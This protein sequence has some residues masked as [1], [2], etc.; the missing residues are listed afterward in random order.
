M[1]K[2][3]FSKKEQEVLPDKPIGFGYK[4]KW[5]AIKSN[6]K[7]KVA[8]LLELK[9]IKKSNW[10][11]GIE[12]GYKK[13]IFITPEINGWIL[14]LGIDISD[15]EI[16][17]TKGLLK[18]VSKKFGECQIFLTHRIVE[19]HFWGLARDGKIERLYSYA[20]ESNE[21]MIIEG[22]PTEAERKYNFVNTFLE[23]ANND[24]YW[25]RENIEF[26]DEDMV[27][28]IAKKWS[29]NPTRIE[30]YEGV[31]GIGLIGN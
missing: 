24:E 3:Y 20:G 19:Y 11:D 7:E 18:R 29:I 27:M 4:N 13:G 28:E 21:N 6:N 30:D 26:P 12:F 2:K 8:E 10:K 25:K 5:L 22:E 15:L 17:S 1:F 23:Q 14:V 16:E 31:E 9:N